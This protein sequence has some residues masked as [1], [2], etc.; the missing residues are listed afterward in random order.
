M[1]IHEVIGEKKLCDTQSA[2][3]LIRAFDIRLSCASTE[4]IFVAPSEVSTIYSITNARKQLTH[5]ISHTLADD[6]TYSTVHDILS[7]IGSSV[8]PSENQTL[9]NIDE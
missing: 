6:A 7:T 1:L 8:K 3:H 5:S 9:F 2:W 4:N